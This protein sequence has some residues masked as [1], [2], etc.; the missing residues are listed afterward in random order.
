MTVNVMNEILYIENLIN[1]SQKIEDMVKSYGIDYIDACLLY[2][3]KNDVEIEQLADI[4]K[5]NQSIKSKLQSEA[6]TLNFIKR[7]NK[8]IQFE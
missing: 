2:C 8:T 3:E 5:K 6:E 7:T 1:I 4:L